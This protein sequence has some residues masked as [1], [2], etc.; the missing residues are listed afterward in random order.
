MVV[1]LRDRHIRIPRLNGNLLASCVFDS[2]TEIRLITEERRETFD[3]D[4]SGSWII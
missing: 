1:G 3:I 2:A 4:C